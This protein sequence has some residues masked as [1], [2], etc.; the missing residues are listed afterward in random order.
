MKFISDLCREKFDIS[1]KDTWN[2]ADIWCI[3]DEKKNTDINNYG[4]MGFQYVDSNSAYNY[5]YLGMASNA[6]LC[7]NWICW[8]W[9]N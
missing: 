5:L 6:I 9:N 3:K 2:P 1:K 7:I 4:M 8:D